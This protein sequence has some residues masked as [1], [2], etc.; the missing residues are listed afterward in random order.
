MGSLTLRQEQK[1]TW[2]SA[3]LYRRDRSFTSKCFQSKYNSLTKMT[4]KKSGH[5]SRKYDPQYIENQSFLG[6]NEKRLYLAVG[7]FAMDNSFPQN[8]LHPD[9]LHTDLC[10]GSESENGKAPFTAE[11]SVRGPS[12][13]DVGQF[14]IF[15]SRHI[16]EKT[17]ASPISVPFKNQ[18]ASHLDCTVCKKVGVSV[19]NHF[20]I[21]V[22]YS[23]DI[24]KLID[25][26]T[27][28]TDQCSCQNFYVS[29][30]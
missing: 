18:V 23:I 25:L 1:H 14:Q 22:D 6:A 9:S 19:E 20:E 29:G 10:D 13:A 15:L 21:L 3:L 7:R 27:A 26:I 8:S 17:G 12:H 16:E 2:T 5:K 28:N 11:F 30:Y 4:K 24:D